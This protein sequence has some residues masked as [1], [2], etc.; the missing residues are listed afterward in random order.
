MRMFGSGSG[1]HGRKL[2][3]HKRRCEGKNML[4]DKGVQN[5][6]PGKWKLIILKTSLNHIFDGKMSIFAG[7]RK[8]FCFIGVKLLSG[9]TPRGCFW[10]FVILYRLYIFV[11]HDNV[12]FVGLEWIGQVIAYG[13]FGAVQVFYRLVKGWTTSSR[14]RNVLKDMP[15]TTGE[16]HDSPGGWIQDLQMNL[17]RLHEWRLEICEGR[18]ISKNLGFS[19]SPAP[20][21][22][23]ANDP[24]IVRHI[25]KDEF[26]KYTKP[27]TS[28]DPFFYY[29]EDFLGSGIFVVKHGVASKD[30]GQEW[31]KMRKVSAQIFNRHSAGGFR[32]FERRILTVIWCLCMFMPC[33]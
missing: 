29:F 4:A 6:D 33:L 27:D 30:D 20:Y 32:S 10:F 22:L 14:M 9:F 31:T 12:M 26:N 5:P 18:P 16:G 3:R 7:R 1:D 19:W 21:T 17:Y 23:L 28:L 13:V 11:D 2:G 25:L 24:Q 8:E 15:S